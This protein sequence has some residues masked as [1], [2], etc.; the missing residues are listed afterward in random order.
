MTVTKIPLPVAPLPDLTPCAGLWELFDSRR[1]EDHWKARRICQGC[2]IKEECRP[3]DRVQTPTVPKIAGR[4][5]TGTP[6]AADGTWGGL[7]YHSGE[8]VDASLELE[9]AEACP[10]CQATALSPCR[11]KTGKATADHKKRHTPRMCARCGSAPAIRRGLYC[12]PCRAANDQDAK[13][14]YTRRM[15][16][17]EAA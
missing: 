14:D 6:A 8:V 2:P 13:N 17:G 12:K 7:L 16:A 10:T 5:N 1:R 9:R 11:T 15:R 4:P 3:P